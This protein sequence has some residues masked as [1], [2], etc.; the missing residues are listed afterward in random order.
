MKKTA[1]KDYTK[2]SEYFTDE[3]ELLQQEIKDTEKQKRFVVWVQEFSK[4]IVV[5]TFIFY[6]LIS[7]ISLIMVFM[8]MQQ[9][10]ISG[11]DTLIAE[12]N[13]TFR[14]IVG[15]YIIKA[16]VENAVK[17]GGNY[18]IGICDARLRSMKNN[19]I[20]KGKMVKSADGNNDSN[21]EESYYTADDI[22]EEDD[23]NGIEVINGT[24]GGDMTL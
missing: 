12:T 17:I 1:Y 24:S 3:N 10:Y 20:K 7:L 6:I 16:A 21:E 18:Y 13:A 14:D 2:A 9:G 5:V 23:Q 11:I 19:M 15:G 8:T 4:K 22:M